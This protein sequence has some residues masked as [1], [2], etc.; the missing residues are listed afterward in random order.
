MHEDPGVTG[1]AMKFQSGDIPVT[2]PKKLIQ[3]HDRKELLTLN[4][5]SKYYKWATRDQKEPRGFVIALYSQFFA[6]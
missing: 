3:P 4:I 6:E 2:I 5:N 1:S